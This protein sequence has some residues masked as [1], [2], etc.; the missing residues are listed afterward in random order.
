MA[1]RKYQKGGSTKKTTT[2]KTT[3]TKT[4]PKSGIKIKS[5]SGIKIKKTGST[6]NKGVVKTRTVKSK[7]SPIKIKRKS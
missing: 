7:K 5:K 6:A 1:V 2:R 4:T 3:T